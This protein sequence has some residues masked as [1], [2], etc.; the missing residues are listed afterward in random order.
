LKPKYIYDIIKKTA[1]RKAEQD[2][3]YE[4]VLRKEQEKE[5]GEFGDKPIYVTAA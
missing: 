3:I 5:K 1:E 2:I 4:K